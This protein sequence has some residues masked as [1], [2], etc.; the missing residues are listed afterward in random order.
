MQ[1]LRQADVCFLRT[2][3]GIRQLLDA[4]GKPSVGTKSLNVGEPSP[5]SNMRG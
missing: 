2:E 3:V 1:V 5:Y 4:E